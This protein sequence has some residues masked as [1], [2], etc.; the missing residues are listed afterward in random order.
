MNMKDLIW[1]RI[2]WTFMKR[3][4]GYDNEEMKIFQQN[5][6]NQDV[7]SKAPTLMNKTII[8]EVVDSHGC[9]SE[10]KV[11]D[12]FYFDGLG[13]LITELCPKRIC[14]HALHAI[15]PQVFA[16]IELIYAGVD[17]NEMRFKRAACF[18]VGLECG[19][20][21]RIVLEVRTEERKEA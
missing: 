4:L 8:A 18:D 16:T 2:Q 21:G 12:K 11:G 3:R 7:I 19:G 14:I 13:N 17:P 5:P 20:F 15:T 10:H 6:R 1:R 9:N